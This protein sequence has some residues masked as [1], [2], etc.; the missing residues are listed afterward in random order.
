[1]T[2]IS[3]AGTGVTGDIEHLKSLPNLTEI[4][5]SNTGVTGNEELFHEYRENAGLE[6]CEIYL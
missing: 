5:L 2:L 3:L 4:C 6:E 1:L